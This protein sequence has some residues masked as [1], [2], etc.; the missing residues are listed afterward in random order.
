[1]KATHKVIAALAGAT[2]LVTLA[3]VMSFW[4]F[5]QIE[6]LAASR[7]HSSIVLNKADDL[8]SSMKDAE[9]GQRGYLL[10]GDK[11]FL[12]PY[13]A[14]RDTIK[15]QL[16]ELQRLSGDS[17]G[18]KHLET[19]APLIDYK[20]AELALVIELREKND[21]NTALSVI[22]KGQGK[23]WMDSI[24]TE[25]DDFIRI[26]TDRR[27]QVIN[28]FDTNMRRMFVII[29][30]TSLL[31]LLLALAFAYFVYR[32]SQQQLLNLVH[33]ETRH[34]LESQKVLNAQLQEANVTLQISEEKF[35]V[36]LFSIGDAVMVTDNGGKV[37]LLNPLAEELTG[38]TQAQAI[39][40]P[41]D[42]VFHIIN[43]DTRQ[44]ATIP[45]KDALEH[46]T[47]QGLANHTVLIAQN[48]TESD[49]ADSCAPIRDREGVVTGAVLVFRDVTRDY[50]LQQTL[51]DS[52]DKYRQ[53]FEGSLDALLILMPP[54]WSF[55]DV[56]PE[57]VRLFAAGNKE[58]LSGLFPG[59]LSPERQPD[60][61]LSEEKAQE[62]IA[63]ALQDGSRSFEWEHRRLNGELFSSDVLLNRIK[64]KGMV[65]LQVTIRDITE[66]KLAEEE[67]LKAGALQNAIFNSANFS[68]IATDAK[69]VIQI[70]NVGA[71][72][73][74]GYTAAEV[75]NKITPA[76][77]SDPKE[78]IARAEALSAELS[79][80]ITP[81]FEALVF[82][83]SRGIEDIYELTYIR[84][85]G[86]RLQAV[87]S[88]TA[89][90]DAQN[91][92]IGYLLIGYDNTARKQIEAAQEI[93][94][95]RLR[96]Q[97][98][99]TRSL[100]ESNIDAI[101]TT[102]PSGIITDINKQME[103]LTGSTR[104]EL[105]GAPFKNYFTDP[106]RAEAGVRQV[107]SEKKVTNY[108]LTLRARNGK[109]TPVSYNA[110]TFY[111][112]DRK[113]QG[114]FAAAR[115][116]TERK[117]LD[118]V[119]I[120]KNV[121]LESAKSM[122]EKANLAKSDF[123]SNMSHE[124]RTPMNAIIGM[125]YLALKTE[126]T[127][128]QR[129]HI[130]KIKGAGQHLLSI[131]NDILD[132]SKIE[133]GKLA[134]ESTEFELEKVLENVANL[135]A[136]K[137][138]AKGLELVFDVDKNVPLNL[139]GD[140]LR[141]GQILINYS[142]NAV[143]FTERGEIDII[144]RIKEQTEHDVLLYC[145]VRDTG[146]GLSQE[147]MGRLFQSF[148]QADTSTTRKF[149]GTGL[150]LVISKRL[151]ELMGGEVGV[152]SIPG[153][154]S[155]FWFT[156]RLGKGVAQQHKLALSSDLQG[157]R[158]LVVD[159]NENAR[160]VLG[161][162]LGNMSFK[163]DHAES[164][165][166]AIGAV[167][168]A[169]AQGK[170]YDILF[171]DWQMPEM[172][173]IEMARQVHELPLNRM[174]HMTMVTAY[175][176]EDIIKGA[177]EAGIED[178][179]IKPVTASVLFDSVV[180]LLGDSVEG[181]RIAGDAPSDTVEQLATIKGARI[182]L[183][184]DN[185]LN[186]EVATELLR[187]VGFIVELA[188]NG[189]VALD[190]VRTA[191]Y[192]I[193]LMDMQ[194]PVMDGVTATQ[195]IRKDARFID[196]PVVAM[197]ANAMQGDRE[198]C[199]AAGMNDH[200]AKPIEP[201]DLW[202]A[203]LKWIKPRNP[204]T[205]GKSRSTASLDDGLPSA[206]EGLDIANGMRRVL[207]KKPLYLWMLRKFVAGQKTVSEEI[208]KALEEDDWGTAERLAHTLKGVSGNIGAVGVQ[209]LATKVESSIKK[210]Q[211]R[212]MINDEMSDLKK[213]LAKLI[214]QLE[215]QLPPEQLIAVVAV[216]PIKLK[217]VCDRLDAL[218][219]NDDSAA[220][221]VMDANAELLSSAFP[222]HYRRI[223]AG[224]QS[225]N[226]ETALAALREATA[227]NS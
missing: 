196:L 154:G 87:V 85:D 188:E 137:T 207:G 178:V 88:V 218:L 203:L 42:E 163:V 121:E 143:K 227:V 208:L 29:V 80:P 19:I 41:V 200:V 194:M 105:I 220:S 164:G 59:N 106:E 192:D 142:N 215:Q 7:M 165:K 158:V 40:R 31:V 15:K 113:L 37:T 155:T 74:L 117:L 129:D 111:D 160:L 22:R 69:G 36:T 223:D 180:R 8:L 140:P 51:R 151:S 144:I 5:G 6:K 183:V 167:D 134:V 216:D 64:A 191:Q 159:D 213:P 79:T 45:V 93:L 133:A 62:L 168:R 20:L 52:E 57:A 89:L 3:A 182:L 60:G 109:E 43:K 11:A 108:E 124:I 150:G 35:A 21:M 177:E 128:R 32:E 103:T 149:G 126:M 173:G 12:E 139:I 181:A 13:L 138:T 157:K 82:K 122:A 131:I 201:E 120:E 50:S 27:E 48:G 72:R 185:E 58:A 90:R 86:T 145:A 77:I 75:M 116:I 28:E 166:E 148:A 81:G 210:R 10:T 18:R 206:I 174:P 115:D 24:R 212:R 189:Q 94:D 76:D 187:D 225:L 23:R 127:P 84:K 54:T 49:I 70:F 26:E 39:G 221:D 147:Q 119:L 209:L 99:Y 67:L 125:S 9:T 112:R 211:P 199:M 219:L 61:R 66:R 34:L 172:D 25:I 175:G 152:E 176:R 92:I 33:L 146:I 123:L 30:I 169:E 16:Q 224:I 197:T 68:S 222:T 98:F 114:V 110:A 214:S 170:P 65:W 71:E 198:R 132:L 107:L 47:I 190:K 104:D 55:T 44:P 217:I 102:D 226:Y 179:L 161:D 100:F 2:L 171:I 91:T 1:L 101:M 56:N 193:V 46:G 195:E 184:E 162:L 97:Q 95:Q 156:A 141:L 78:V 118:Q 153:K 63:G 135:I 136:E 17:T 130:K 73:M 186:Q 14:V 204:A 38:W 205:A 202:K 83:A 53:L 4:S 96:D